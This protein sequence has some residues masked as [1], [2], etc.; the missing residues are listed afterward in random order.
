MS[1]YTND[2]VVRRGISERGI[3]FLQKPFTGTAL[4]TRVHEVLAASE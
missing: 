3:R 4:A 1:G 2:A